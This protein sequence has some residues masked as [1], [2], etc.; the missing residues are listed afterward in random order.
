MVINEAI[1]NR[2]GARKAIDIPDNILALLN[3]GRLETV[4][5][6]EWVVYSLPFY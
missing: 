4:N 2:K 5:L 6:I 1:L 3:Q